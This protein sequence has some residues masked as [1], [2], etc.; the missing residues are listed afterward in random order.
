MPCNIQMTPTDFFRKILRK[1]QNGN[2]AIAMHQLAGVISSTFPSSTD[3]AGGI[4]WEDILM[5]IYNES[6]EAINVIEV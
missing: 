2:Y 4:T 5:L 3:C 6:K 1:D